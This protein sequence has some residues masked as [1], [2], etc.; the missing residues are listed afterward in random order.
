[1]ISL[2]ITIAIVGLIVYL[3]ETYVPMPQPF[4]IAI[5]VVV[6][7]CLILYLVQLFGLDLPVPFR[8]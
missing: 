3:V 8:R 1:M 7:L 5:R 2:I 4:K 6:I